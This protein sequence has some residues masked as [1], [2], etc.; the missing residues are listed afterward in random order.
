LKNSPKTNIFFYKSNSILYWALEKTLSI[1][2]IVGGIVSLGFMSAFVMAQE[3]IIGATGNTP[4][5]TMK[6]GTGTDEIE[7]RLNDGTGTFQIFDV[8]NGRSLMLIDPTTENTAVGNAA[9]AI[10]DFTIDCATGV[11]N[12]Q[13]RANAG[14]A[15]NTVK[16]LQAG[17]SGGEPRFRLWDEHW[18]GVGKLRFDI[19]IN[20]ATGKLYFKN[21]NDDNTNFIVFEVD[22][23]PNGNLGR[24]T[25]NTP[26]H[27]LV[28]CVMN[29]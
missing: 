24:V 1:L 12:I 10:Q 19:T 3:I 26:V 7:I 2:L 9:T 21:I 8:K 17:V 28:G 5:I 15:A 13:T 20:E 6:P 22:I 14:D 18:N 11:C 4:D 23:D 25:F 29:C 27:D 16:S